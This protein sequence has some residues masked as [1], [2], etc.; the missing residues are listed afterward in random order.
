[1]KNIGKKTSEELND[2][3]KNS[4]T[5]SNL[6]R[7]EGTTTRTLAHPHILSS[8]SDKKQHRFIRASIAIAG[9]ALVQLMYRW[10][11]V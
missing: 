4:T 2:G 7:N 3:G 1:L 9:I 6:N 8:Q 11:S 10:I 5:A